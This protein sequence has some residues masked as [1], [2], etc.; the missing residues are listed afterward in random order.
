[1]CRKVMIAAATRSPCPTDALLSMLALNQP[2]LLCKMM[3]SCKLKQD[4]SIA[5]SGRSI[6]A[7]G[8]G[9]ACIAADIGL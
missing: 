3:C 1:M 2:S 6:L 9:R 5:C 8:M 4:W 7:Q